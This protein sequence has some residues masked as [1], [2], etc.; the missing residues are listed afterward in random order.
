MSAF[1][2]FP[3]TRPPLPPEAARLHRAIYE[4]NR[5]GATAASSLSLRMEAWLHRQVAAD[6]VHGPSAP[7]AIATLEIGAGTLN[8][9]PFEPRV[10]P[11]DIVEPFRALYEGSALLPR[12]R[13][14]YDDIAAVPPAQRY[15]RITSVA[16]F[17]HLTDLPRIVA[18]AGRLLAPGGALRVAVPSE[19]TPLWTLGWRL[20][21]GLEFRLR[22]RLDYGLL[23]RH[24]HVNT[25]REVEEVLRHF[26]GRVATRVLGLSRGLSLYQFHECREPLPGR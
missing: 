19:G 11:Y 17:E 9:L 12:I 4:A 1:P 14:I 21:T 10:G 25:A 15:D 18:A 8:Q 5:R 13:A 16:T 23:L 24:E 2:Q 22:H 7:G 3:K 26:F 6:V 20:T